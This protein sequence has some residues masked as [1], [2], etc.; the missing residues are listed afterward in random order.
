MSV[1]DEVDIEATPNYDI[2]LSASKDLKMAAASGCLKQ[3]IMF[4]ARTDLNDFVPHMDLGA[5]LQRFIGEPNTREN[6]RLAENRLFDS[7]TK[8]ARV[9]VND[10]RVKAV[11]ISNESI[12]MYTFV[13]TSNYDINIITA[14]VLDFEN[15]IQNNI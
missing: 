3:D 11:P 8:D 12:A 6:A 14:T 15:G 10:L 2:L 7:L 9:G 5:D 4:R 1:Y 13:N